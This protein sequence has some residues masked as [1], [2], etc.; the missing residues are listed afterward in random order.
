MNLFLLFALTMPCDV[1]SSDLIFFLVGSG[2]L[3]L[4][5]SSVSSVLSPLSFFFLFAHLRDLILEES[6]LVTTFQGDPPSLQGQGQGQSQGQIQI[7]IK[8]QQ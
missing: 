8:K 1:V 7:V 5:V 2:E 3:E 4:S 6:N